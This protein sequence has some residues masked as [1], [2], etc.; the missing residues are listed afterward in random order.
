MTLYIKEWTDDTATV[1]TEN[2]HVLCIFPSLEEAQTSCLED[3][4]LDDLQAAY[5]RE[6]AADRLNAD[7]SSVPPAR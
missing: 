7:T 5:A 4:T 2:G 1:M 6:Y 3:Y